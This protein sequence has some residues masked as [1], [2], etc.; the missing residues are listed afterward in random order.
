MDDALDERGIVN[1]AM[2]QEP[3]APALPVRSAWIVL[4][5]GFVAAGTTATGA[6]FVA[7]YL[8]P[9]FRDPDDVVAYLNSPVLASLSKKPCGRLSA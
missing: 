2:A 8:N 1:V 3:T 5:F 7:D 9:V 4:A 6:A